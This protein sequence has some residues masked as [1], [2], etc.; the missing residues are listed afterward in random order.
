[1]KKIF[2]AA[3]AALTLVA[4]NDRN[5]SELKESDFLTG[6][7][8][9]QVTFF[10]N[11]GAHNVDGVV[12]SELLPIPDDVE[13]LAKVD[14]NE[15]TDAGAGVNFKQIKATSKGNGVFEVDIPAGE[16]QINV[17]I[18]ANGF[19]A[20]YY[21]SPEK[22]PIKAYYPKKDG[23][24]F[25]VLAGQAFVEN[26]PAK[27][28][29]KQPTEILNNDRTKT[30]AVS[31]KLEGKKEMWDNENGAPKVDNEG[32]KD[33]ELELSIKFADPSVDSRE[34]VF[35][36]KTGSDGSYK[37]ADLLLYDEWVEALESDPAAL[38][39]KI[40]A[41]PWV[42]AEFTHYY[43]S[44]EGSAKKCSFTQAGIG[45]AT[46]GWNDGVLNGLYYLND[47]SKPV[48]LY[49][50]VQ[51]KNVKVLGAWEVASIAI[52]NLQ[53]NVTLYGEALDQDL[54]AKF[55]PKSTT[56]ILGVGSNGSVETV[57]NAADESVDVPQTTINDLMGWLL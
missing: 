18:I 48:F 23:L 37:F 11:P 35:K 29:F 43:K 41:K 36:T 34:L 13:V 38:E 25:A 45:D 27:T 32:L 15:Y 57:T 19:T 51:N 53:A 50:W 12:V 2:L 22:E 42:D 24:L 14:Y 10:Y 9:I 47:S 52:G 20:D 7:S 55:T 6:K 3:L 5:Q 40:S 39:T 21:T 16:R 8:T 28:T 54:T 49:Q 31:G 33:I 30:F 44:R 56:D 46:I 4:C 26:D 17:E 1:M